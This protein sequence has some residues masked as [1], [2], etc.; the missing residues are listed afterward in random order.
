MAASNVDVILC[1]ICDVQHTSHVAD[2]WCPECDEGLCSTCKNYHSISKASRQHGIISIDDYKKLPVEICKIE[3]NC[4][5]HDKKFQMFCPRHDQL[6]CIMYVSENH[7]ECT[8]MFLIDDA[9][10]SS[11]S[12]TLFDSLEKTLKDIQDNIEKVVKDREA[13]LDKIKQHHLKI[14]NDIKDKRRNVNSRLDE[15][16]KTIIDDLNSTETQLKLKIEALLDKLS[17]K[18]TTIELLKT[19]IMS[20]KQHGSDLQAFIGSKM[21]EKDVS[22]ELK[23]IQNLSEDDG[24]SQLGLKCQIDD[25]IT[26]ILSKIPAFGSITIEKSQSPIVIGVGHQMQAQTFTA[27][28]SC[29]RSF[30]DIT[31]S[32][33]GD[34]K[35]PEGQYSSCITGSS[36]F[37]DG[38]IILADCHLNNRLI[39]VQSD[40]SLSTEIRLSSLHPF[41][42]TCIDDK[43]VAVTTF[44][45]NKIQIIDTK[46]KQVTKTIN[47]GAGGGITYR[48]G[49]II[50]CEKGKGIVGIQLSNFKIY[51]LVEDCTIKY[52]YSY[53][54]TSGENLYY[55]DNRST[56]KCY[57]LKGDKHW[58]YNNK[59]IINGVTGISVNQHGIVS[60]ISN[61]NERVVLISSDGKNSRT[62]LTA[63]DGITNSYGMYFHINNLRVVSYSG[64]LLKFD[65]A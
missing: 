48:Q 54:A 11:R 45:N 21:L 28:P 49:H 64:K 16:E 3:Q 8:G 14:L 10:K 38:R 4:T 1:G 46:N 18:M 53:I 22:D 61:T 56:V 9:I 30:G 26:V 2:Y 39:I 43:T 12:S 24:F 20:V 65:I 41:D 58:E 25:K 31:A 51:T 35:V 7:K 27:V 57:S 40:G 32:L 52:D 50:Y 47:T 17:T 33:I 59:S 37:P 15:L 5:E 29:S 44:N 34:V 13:N 62:L 63:K 55:T 36:V 19:N 60:V 6:C 23:C 42:V